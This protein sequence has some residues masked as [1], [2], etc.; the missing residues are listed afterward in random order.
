MFTLRNAVAAQQ[1]VDDLLD[2]ARITGSKMRLDSMSAMRGAA[3][4][5][6]RSLLNSIAGRTNAC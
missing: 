4:R 6:A 2:L 1:L 3:F 5:M